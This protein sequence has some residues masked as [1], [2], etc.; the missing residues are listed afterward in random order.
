MKRKKTKRKRKRKRNR[1]RKRKRKRSKKR[2]RKRKRK[3]RGKGRVKALIPV[4]LKHCSIIFSTSQNF[5]TAN[6]PRIA[7]PHG[8]ADYPSFRTVQKCHISIASR[9]SSSIG[10][11]TLVPA[12]FMLTNMF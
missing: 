7:N 11:I 5:P 3:G 9:Y 6:S 12:L 8:K 1:K 4:N 2:K 10:V